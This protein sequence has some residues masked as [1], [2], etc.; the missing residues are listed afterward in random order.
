[1]AE[2]INTQ[3]YYIIMVLLWVLSVRGS[4][5]AVFICSLKLILEIQRATGRH[6]PSLIISLMCKQRQ[7]MA[8]ILTLSASPKAP[9][10]ISNRAT[11]EARR[12]EHSAFG[13]SLVLVRIIFT[14]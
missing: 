7:R 2:P 1:M 9:Q 5:C 10:Q 11:S 12:G 4:P 8:G 3:E 6:F 13:P 14:F